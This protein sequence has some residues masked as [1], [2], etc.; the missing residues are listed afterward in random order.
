VP[1]ITDVRNTIWEWTGP[2][3]PMPDDNF[4]LTR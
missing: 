1:R 3:A 4:K 2:V